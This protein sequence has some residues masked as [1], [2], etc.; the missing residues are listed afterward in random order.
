M[1]P[2]PSTRA[3]AAGRLDLWVAAALW[4]VVLVPPLVLVPTAVDS[5]R[6]PK[7]LAA[8]TLGLVS[9]ALLAGRLRALPA[10]EPRRLWRSPAFLAVAPLLAVA[11]L[12]L[13]ATAH[14]E[15]VRAALASFAIGAACLVGW[16]LG[17][18]AAE[19][20]RF[21]TAA[22][23][24]G[25]LLALIAVLQYHQVFQPFGFVR[26]E[27]GRLAVTSLAGNSGD[28]GAF[29]AFAALCAQA[30]AFAAAGRRRWLWAGAALLCGYGL[31]ATQ[32]LTAV[33]AA[34][35]ASL[36]YWLAL[37]PRRR[38]LAVG[39]IVLLLA[40]VGVVA[41]APLRERVAAMGTA[42]R[43]GDWGF[44]SS[45]RL[46]GWRAALWML[47]RHPWTGVG[48]GAYVTEFAP[49]KLDLLS[50]GVG[51][52]PLPGIA[53]F[54]HAHS[55]FLQVAAETGLPGLLALAWGLALLAR[56]AW[57]R[58]GEERA[59]AAAGLV[60]FLLLAVGHFPFRLALVAYPAL[61]F[62][63]WLLR[64]PASL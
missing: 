45:Y 14:P 61:L 57:R 12:G 25:T 49:A 24:P 51:F 15:H 40:G 56:A 53:T 2:R 41:T 44:A 31:V 38:A 21:A 22:A 59:L 18:G 63:A 13:A 7:L 26:G 32:S 64:P 23:V 29:L 37:L 42:L 60:L 5:F 28:A 9:L 46:D 43:E 20:R 11:A 1:P 36:V 19:R 33:V 16:S 6:L 48:Q 30:G 34:I 35:G 27:R 58:A 52:S 8:E 50:R 4:A 17:L 10:I 55:E 54:E 62:L 3:P 39:A 47:S